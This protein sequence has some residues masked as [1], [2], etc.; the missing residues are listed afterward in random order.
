MAT[1]L[2]ANN[3]LTSSF[4]TNTTSHKQPSYTIQSDSNTQD[5]AR[6]PLVQNSTPSSIQASDSCSRQPFRRSLSQTQE[7][8]CDTQTLD[9]RNYRGILSS[10]PASGSGSFYKSGTQS[11]YGSR[12]TSPEKQKVRKIS[13]LPAAPPSMIIT[14]TMTPKRAQSV[15]RDSCDKGMTL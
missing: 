10:K 5:N 15:E 14:P 13:G 7:S 9:R 2:S 6:V 12:G 8:D 11:A 3:T 1:T 4:S